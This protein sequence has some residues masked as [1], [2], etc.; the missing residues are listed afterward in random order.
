MSEEKLTGLLQAILTPWIACANSFIRLIRVHWN[1]SYIVLVSSTYLTEGK[2]ILV[3]TPGEKRSE[4]KT[5]GEACTSLFSESNMACCTVS[6]QPS[7]M[8]SKTKK[9][10]IT[11]TS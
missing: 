4:D 5:V 3:A 10:S 11:L 9:N 6:I 7:I 1:V 8:P 2:V